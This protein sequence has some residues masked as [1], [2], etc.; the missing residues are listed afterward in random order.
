[1][2]VLTIKELKKIIDTHLQNFPHLGDLEVKVLIKDPKTTYG[3]RPSVLV[4]SAHFGFDWENGLL[5]LTEKQVKLV[6]DE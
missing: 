6:K 5:L 3:A 4:K 1:M 2:E